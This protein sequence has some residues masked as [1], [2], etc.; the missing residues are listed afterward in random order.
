MRIRVCSQFNILSTSFD[1]FMRLWSVMFAPAESDWRAI[2][3]LAGGMWDGLEQEFRFKYRR[4][5]KPQTLLRW[6]RSSCVSAGQHTTPIQFW[7]LCVSGWS[8]WISSQ[9]WPRARTTSEAA[10]WIKKQK[11]VI[12]SVVNSKKK[13]LNLVGCQED[14]VLSSI[15]ML[16]VQNCKWMTAEVFS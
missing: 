14:M 10:V 16:F 6:R 9:S 1:K 12:F 11:Y 7:S 3:E 5:L 8:L 15:M 2:E 4:F 13:K